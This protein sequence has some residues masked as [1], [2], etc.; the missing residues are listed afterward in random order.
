MDKIKTVW[1]DLDGVLVDFLGGL[2]RAL[3]IPYDINHYPYEKG[4]WNMLTDIKELDDVPVTFEQ[5]NDACTKNFWENLEWM[6][7]GHDV[8]RTVMRY[9]A[10]IDICLLTTC[11]PNPE[12]VSGKLEWIRRNLPCFYNSAII[13]DVDASKVLYARPDALLIDDRNKN[14]NEFIAAGSQGLLV[15]RPWNRAHFY[16]DK[17]FEVVEKFLENLNVEQTSHT[18]NM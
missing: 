2:H 1:L 13:L 11:M 15:P 18:H 14:I 10:P 5:C 12:S 9:F 17:T 7:D 6:H 8:L 4:K 3:D 16:A